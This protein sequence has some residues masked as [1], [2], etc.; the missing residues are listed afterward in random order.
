[1]PELPDVEAY[2]R[3]FDD[4]ATGRTVWRVVVTDEG[5]LRNVTSRTLDRALRGHRF[6]TPVRHGKWLIAPTSG[7]SVLLHFG[8][9]GD[10]RWA[11][12]ASG[13]HRHD[14]VIFEL[15]GG[16][17]RYRNMR[18]LG[19]LWM[20]HDDGETRVATGELGPDALD[21]DLRR[22]R[23]LLEA[24]RGTIKPF[25]MNQRNLAGVGNLIADEALWQA[26][27]HPLRPI[28][29]LSD[30]EVRRLHG[31]LRHVLRT[32]IDRFDY[33]PA[34]RGW[35]TH[36]RGHPGAKCPRCR[37][38]LERSVVGG[39]TTYWCPRCQPLR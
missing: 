28:A 31:K 34:L 9:T 14:R 30:D 3:F 20:A 12:D 7:P 19:G 2:R 13:R 32:A 37:T 36:V 6:E 5:I 1:M 26:R 17:L 21:V 39:R 35:L 25:L 33:V 29:S 24:R 22:F 16:E 38:P 23:S 18:K 15:D 4:H 8:M 27:I 10:L 11:E